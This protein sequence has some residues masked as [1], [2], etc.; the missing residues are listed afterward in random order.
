MSSWQPTTLTQQLQHWQQQLRQRWVM[1]MQWHDLLFMHYP[2]PGNLLRPHI[3]AGLSID[4][5]HG[6]AYVAVVPFVMRHVRPRSVPSMPWVSF[7]PEINLRTYVTALDRDR[8]PGVWFFSLDAHNPLAVRLAR[9]LFHLPYFDAAMR[10]NVAYRSTAYRSTNDN[11]NIATSRTAPSTKGERQGERKGERW[12][13]YK[14][15]R[16][17]RGNLVGFEGAYRPIGEPFYA[18]AGSLEHFLVERYC[19]YSCDGDGRIYRGDIQHEPW[20]LQTAA[21]ELTHNNLHEPWDIPLSG[22]PLLHYG[23]FLD[24]HAYLPR[25]VRDSVD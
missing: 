9:S 7:F 22:E 4:T 18:R 13:H 12:L 25:L 14:S 19:F 1:S 16:Q 17:Q 15:V 5:F 21:L 23:Q 11:T 3:P 20:A 10:A 24:V 2:V 8:K 6:N